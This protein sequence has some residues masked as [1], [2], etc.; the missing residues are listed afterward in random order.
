MSVPVIVGR[1]AAALLGVDPGRWAVRLIVLALAAALL[2]MALALLGFAVLLGLGG[3]LGTAP[4]GGGPVRGGPPTGAAVAEIP[5]DQ[6]ALMQSVAASSSCHVPW[7]VLAA[8]ASI[9]SGFGQS[10][11]Q[12][13]SAQAYGY[14][15]FLKDTW[16]A[17]GAGI[18]WQ[19]GDAAER[20]RPVDQRPDSTNYHYALPAMARYLCASGAGRDLRAAI[21]AYN[22]ADWYVAEVLQ[23]A[24]RYGGTGASGGGLVSGW[25]DMAALNQYDRRNYASEADWLQWR[26][27]ACSAASLDWLLRAYG[28]PVASI[29]AAIQLIAPGTGISPS[30]GLLDATG[31]PLARAIIARGLPARNAQLRSIP[32]LKVWLDRGPLA[33]DGARWFGEGH[34]FVAVGYDDGGVYTRDSS[35]WDTRYL[36][37]DRLYGQVGFSGWV[38]GVD[39]SGR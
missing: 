8:I 36:T 20:A 31:R 4:S 9:E 21:W 35:G 30:L 18:A 38:V 28:A 33:L 2:P 1:A 34:W 16:N 26:A 19:A 7:T 11:D 6:L 37:W 3:G 24:A 22:H 12:F 25:S 23:L 15:Q 14:G 39:G 32:E 17:Y 27:A 10:A 13:S 5:A 29:D